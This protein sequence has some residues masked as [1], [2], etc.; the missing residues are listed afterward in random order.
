M[1]VRKFWKDL[2]FRDI[3]GPMQSHGLL[4]AVRFMLFLRPKDSALR[5]GLLLNG[6]VLEPNVENLHSNTARE[7]VNIIVE[8]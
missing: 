5:A 7:T 6:V 8:Y 3:Y 1:M 4:Q 2:E